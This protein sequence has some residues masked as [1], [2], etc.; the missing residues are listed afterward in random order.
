MDTSVIKIEDLDDIKPSTSSVAFPKTKSYSN[1]KNKQLRTQQFIKDKR[2]IRK[3]CLQQ[4]CVY[5][6]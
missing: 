3:V 2:E 4:L 5:W 6:H 1:I